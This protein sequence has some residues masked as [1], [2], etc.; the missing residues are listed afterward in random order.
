MTR[1]RRVARTSAHTFPLIQYTHFVDHCSNIAVDVI[2]A[3]YFA[4]LEP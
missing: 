3:V 1:P 4:Q 2:A